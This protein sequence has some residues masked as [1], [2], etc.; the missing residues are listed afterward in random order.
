MALSGRHGF[1]AHTAAAAAGSRRA[2]VVGVNGDATGH[3]AHGHNWFS[4]DFGF[5][6]G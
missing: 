2:R 6:V 1:T 4:G 3:L 5:A